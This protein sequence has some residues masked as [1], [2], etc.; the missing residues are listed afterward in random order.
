MTARNS[1]GDALSVLLLADD[2][3]AHAPN[4]LEH[5]RA[6]RRFSRHRVDTFNP[7]GLRRS[8][9][10]RLDDYDVVVVHYTL[11]VLSDDYLASWFRGQLATFGGLKVQFIQ[12]EYRRVDAVVERI[13]ELDVD[14][15]FSSMPAD[16]AAH[17]YGPRLPGVDVLSTLTGYVP[18]EL[19]GGSRSSLEGRPLDVVY[20]GRSIPY[21]LG[22]LGQD[23]AVI[24]REFAARA[25]TTGLRCD[26]AWTEGERIYG[27][28]WYR[29]L[30]SARATL[31][32]ESGASIVDF[33]GSI[34]QRTESYLKAHPGATFDE[35]ERE[36]LA[37]FEGNAIIQA[38]SPRVFEAAALGT[39]MVNFVGRYSDVIEPWTH[40]VPLEKDFSNFD[41]VLAAIQDDSVL[42]P[43][44][45]RAHEDLVASGRYSLQTFVN[46]FDTEVD[47]RAGRAHGR[48]RPRGVAGLNR[49]LL[50]LEQ[51]RSRERRAELPV[52]ASLRTRALERVEARLVGRFP[53]IEALARRQVE[54][55][56]GERVVHDLVRLA[57]AAAA[58][59][60]ELRYF[61]AP[62]DV[63][64][65][66]DE[67]A[68]RLTLVGVRKPP[69]DASELDLLRSRVE[70]AV[71]EGRLEE[72]V[73]DNSALGE[74]FTFVTIPITSLEVGYHVV[75]GAHRFSALLEL[76][77]R[78]PHG[79]TAALEPLF[80]PRPDAPVAELDRRILAL[81]RIL[82]RPR[83]TTALWA[84]TVRAGLG[85][86]DLRRLLR[87]YLGCHA[88]RAEAPIDLLF[89]DFFRLRLIG[90]SPTSLEVEGRTLVYRTEVSGSQNAVT[91]DSATVRSLDQIVW[92][93]SA[94]GTS[95]SSKEDPR[96]SVTLDG[97]THE[98]QA[99]TPLARRFPELAVPALDRAART[100]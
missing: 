5:I 43:I 28:E 48:P 8:R 94:V 41:D 74:S 11:V 13:R 31:G 62:F 18:W 87:A 99:F 96:I 73:W 82:S 22:R 79:V 17:V 85:S 55:P 86:E 92:D 7:R 1:N 64:A 80:R 30:G 61:G 77:R 50:P 25:A 20:R 83:E 2:S 49:K 10:L 71:R 24:G 15:L 34:Q 47:A 6:F 70:L 36:I 59:L 78:D 42:E 38:V 52:V 54:A 39:A 91:L 90:E 58:H 27:E 66:F 40:Y 51:L 84:A 26:I 76:A 12:D 88:A 46:G 19:E 29:F 95:V 35:V 56:Q 98:F 4:V 100:P 9:L 60:R 63:Q 3:R 16:V 23:K 97:G 89:K 93:H 67:E 65:E 53:E 72:I 32:T 21:W 45:S 33:D 14:L 44:A 68:G 37:P 57:T 75:V 69:E 81:L